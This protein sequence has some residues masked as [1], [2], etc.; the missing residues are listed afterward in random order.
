MDVYR[1]L[2]A[3]GAQPARDGRL[4]RM[5]HVDKRGRDTSADMLL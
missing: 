5:G 4:A 1:T 2:K 3:R